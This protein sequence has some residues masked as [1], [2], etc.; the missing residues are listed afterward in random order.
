MATILESFVESTTFLPPDLQRHLNTIKTLDE[1]CASLS[2]VLQRNVNQL[3][4]MPS[5][6]T[7]GVT[8]EY[9]E[10][11]KRVENDQRQ[12]LQFADEKVTSCFKTI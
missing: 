3:L 1:K 8:D 12:L 6:H 9:L 2:D 10:L 7:T 4:L 5:A 11:S